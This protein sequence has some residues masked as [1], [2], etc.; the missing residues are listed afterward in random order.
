MIQGTA[1]NVSVLLIVVGFAIQAEA[2]REWRLEAGLPLLAF[3]R[4]QQ[5]R[6]FAADVGAKAMVTMQLE[7]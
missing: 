4:F 3:Q 2:G 6:F 1:A 7:S 5:R